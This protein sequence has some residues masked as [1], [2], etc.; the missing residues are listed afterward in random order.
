[1]TPEAG[2]LYAAIDTAA[3]AILARY[4][5]ASNRYSRFVLGE[6]APARYAYQ[7]SLREMRERPPLGHLMFMRVVAEVG[8]RLAW[9]ARDLERGG[10]AAIRIA[11]DGLVKQDLIHLR[12]AIKALRQDPTEVQAAIDAI[13]A[14]AA[15]NLAEM[16]TAAPDSANSYAM[17]RF[18]SA[19]VHPG[20]G[21][22]GPL[23][24]IPDME[25]GL[26]DTIVSCIVFA[27]DLLEEL[28]PE[29]EKVDTEVLLA[30]EVFA[31]S[32]TVVVHRLRRTM[33]QSGGAPV[34][35]ITKAKVSVRITPDTGERID[36]EIELRDGDRSSVVTA[37][38]NGPQE[39]FHELAR[40][41]RDY[42]S[43]QSGPAPES[44]ESKDG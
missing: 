40:A 23:Y 32:P 5:G 27:S 38:G 8:V 25:I 44:H 4:Q 18:A 3:G 42:L 7:R 20:E 10:A 24:A 35:V 34:P 28:E 39:A 12:Q 13:T 16:S 26:R 6:L 29:I 36:Y 30:R 9:I 11:A 17:H 31:F 41:S 22:R 2:E 43:N 33:R 15:G 19:L 21:M 37:G 1:M 14:P